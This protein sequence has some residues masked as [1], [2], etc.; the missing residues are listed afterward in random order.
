MHPVLNDDKEIKIVIGYGLDITNIKTIQ[1]QVEQSEK[2]YRDLIDN[3]MAIIT[4][5]DLDGRFI[6]VNPM[7]SKVYGYSDEEMIG[8][9]I[10]EFMLPEDKT[11]FST[12]YLDT[13]KKT[14]KPLAF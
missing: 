12:A 9:Q 8:H 11:M 1:K 7:V 10:T 3:S 14:K 5:H 4:T 13:I 6:H 2:S